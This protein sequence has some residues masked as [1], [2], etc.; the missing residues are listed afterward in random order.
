MLLFDDNDIATLYALPFLVSLALPRSLS[1][2]VP[3]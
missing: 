1:E 3:T 2:Q